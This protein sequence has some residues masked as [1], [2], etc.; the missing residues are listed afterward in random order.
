ML[1]RD[2]GIRATL[3]RDKVY[4]RIRIAVESMGRFRAAVMPHLLPE[5][6]YKLP[7]QGV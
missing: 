1:Q 5:M 3:N 4:H 6:A 7:Y 2:L